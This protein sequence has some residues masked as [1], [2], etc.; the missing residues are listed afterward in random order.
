MRGTRLIET[1]TC[2]GLWWTP[3]EPD[4]RLNGTLTITKGDPRLDVVG[5]F[6]HEVISESDGERTYSMSLADRERVVGIT[7]D[8]RSVMA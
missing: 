7:T 2:R 4:V 6:G 5:D 8:G 3:S 1:H